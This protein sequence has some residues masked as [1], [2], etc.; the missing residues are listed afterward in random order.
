MILPSLRASPLSLRAK[1]SNPVGGPS[2]SG[3]LRRFAP[4]NDN[5]SLVIVGKPPVIASEAKQSSRRLSRLDCFVASLLAMTMIL[6]SLR[7]APRYCERSEAIQRGG[8]PRLDCFVA[9]LL[10]MTTVLPSLRVS[11][12]SL[13]AKRSNPERDH[14]APTLT[15]PA[16]GDNLRNLCTTAHLFPVN[17]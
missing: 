8:H 9:T 11:P 4:R 3:L 6:P 16:I 17:S 2:S 5:D 15:F 10:A 13:R 1:R 14:D 12:P 7:A